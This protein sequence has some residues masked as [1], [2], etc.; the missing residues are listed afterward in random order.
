MEYQETQSISHKI[1]PLNLD[2]EEKASNNISIEVWYVNFRI[3]E[4]GGRWGGI[5]RVFECLKLVGL[6]D[7]PIDQ[8]NWPEISLEWK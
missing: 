5:Y 8:A 6:F 2:L 3:L 1:W 7:Q 4:N